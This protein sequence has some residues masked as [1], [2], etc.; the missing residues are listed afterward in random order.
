MSKLQELMAKHY[1]ARSYSGRGM[2]GKS[3]LGFDLNC[4]IGMGRF[5][6]TLIESTLGLSQDSIDEIAEQIESIQTDHMGLGMIVYFPGVE[7]YGEGDDLDDADFM[8][9]LDS[10]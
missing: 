4:G 1:P 10:D 8:V 9:G 5:L 6:S 7:F 2:F 3:C